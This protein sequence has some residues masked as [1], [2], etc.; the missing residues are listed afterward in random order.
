MDLIWY[1]T[2]LKLKKLL[3]PRENTLEFLALLFF[4]FMGLS[5]G[6]GL[7]G[8]L[9]GRFLETPD[10]LLLAFKNGF[11]MLIGIFT[12]GR[13]Y[14]PVY[15][16]LQSC[17]R[18]FHPV[19]PLP[20][21][22][23]HYLNDLLSTY[24]LA[25]GSFILSVVAFSASLDYLTGLQFGFALVGTHCVRRIIQTV[26]ENNLIL[27]RKARWW[28]IFSL[29][30]M[31]LAMSG[32]VFTKGA[33]PLVSGAVFV[34]LL[35][36]G[37]VV[38]E[39]TYREGAKGQQSEKTVRSFSFDLIWRNNTARFSLLI[40]FLF[41]SILL[42]IDIVTYQQKG[43]HLFGTIVIVWFFASP[44]ILFTYVFNNTWGYWRNFW[45]LL[46]RSQA[47]GWAV[48]NMGI[49]LLWIPLL[50]DF[51]ISLVYFSFT[52]QLLVPGLAMYLCCAFVLG[53]FSF[54]WSTQFPSFIQ[55]PVSLKTNTSM[56]SS[57]AT[58]L[59]VASLLLL[60]VS[61]WFYLLIPLYL[62]LGS[63]VLMGLTK[64]YPAYREK[65][66]LTLYK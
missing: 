46:E 3:N 20:R 22:A 40:A 17:F 21:F 24:F 66:F 62:L 30:A 35:F 33:Y 56:L 26:S 53:S 43:S 48:V 9:D 65:V 34:L 60:F 23:L 61:P 41:K 7:A 28:L 59:I 52:D 25:F 57:I 42:V 50:A 51:L 8:L 45:L 55:N 18:P 31:A 27:S 14:F 37:Y 10:H 36:A 64:E 16:P 58:V 32:Q 2:S 47:D 4:V 1:F 5:Y 38:E 6:W 54:F 29:S 49:R 44:A 15:T 13:G 11:L 12:L 39:G 19:G 63:L